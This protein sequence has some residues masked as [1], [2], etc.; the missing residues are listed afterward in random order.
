MF[1]YFIFS[2][3]LWEVEFCTKS[4]PCLFV[5]LLLVMLIDYWK[6]D[7]CDVVDV[8]LCGSTADVDDVVVVGWLL[9][10]DD[11]FL[12]DTVKY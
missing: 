10:V 7:G 5:Q 12:M 4:R 2:F 1:C 9:V 6:N 3:T 8:T 11:D